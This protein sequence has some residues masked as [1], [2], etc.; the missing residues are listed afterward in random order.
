MT[1]N[2]TL[3][4]KACNLF[5]KTRKIMIHQIMNAHPKIYQKSNVT[6]LLKVTPIR[7]K[8]RPGIPN[9]TIRMKKSVRS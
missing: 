8:V 4:H 5:K 7:A 2:F 1:H 6:I 3:F 9:R